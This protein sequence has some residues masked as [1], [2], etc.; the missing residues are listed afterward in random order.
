[1][2]LA[3]LARLMVMQYAPVLFLARCLLAASVA[4][5]P[6]DLQIEQ[7]FRIMRDEP[8]TALLI[9]IN[10]HRPNS[11]FAD[12][13]YSVADAEAMAR[14]LASTGFDYRT[15]L[16]LDNDAT[17]GAVRAE[18]MHAAAAMSHKGTLVVYFSGNGFELNRHQFL[19]MYDTDIQDLEGASLG[20]DELMSLLRASGIPRMVVIV[21]AC[22]SHGGAGTRG[23]PLDM[24]GPGIDDVTFNKLSSLL[25][26]TGIFVL[27]AASAGQASYEVPEFQ[28]GVFT[29]FLLEG[30]GGQGADPA[31]GLITLYRLAEFV[32]N[33][34]AHSDVARGQT[35]T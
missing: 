17:R 35:P 25:S 26:G 30:L 2:K 33:R 24:P 20:M 16:L 14:R 31:N 29:H 23:V 21:D 4:G 6:R 15:T 3:N 32:R 1:M 11:G 9:G 7:Q 22:R 10:K 34:M 27:N 18:L 13:R 5:L 28:H 8:R 12:L 19:T